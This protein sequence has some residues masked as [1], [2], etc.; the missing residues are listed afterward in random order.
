MDNCYSYSLN[1]SYADFI[2][3]SI[4]PYSGF[5]KKFEN[6]P[7]VCLMGMNLSTSRLHIPLNETD[8]STDS[9]IP[10]NS[11][12][13]LYTPM[14]YDPLG[15]TG[16]FNLRNINSL[17]LYGNG[18]LTAIIDTGVDYLNPYLI[19]SFGNSKIYRLWDQGDTTK[20][21]P[22][23]YLYGSEYTNEE[24]NLAI[25]SESA[26]YNIVPSKPSST[27]GTNLAVL[28]CGND[29][30]ND[31]FSGVAPESKLIIV[32]LKQ[33]K[34]YLLDYYGVANNALAF[35]EN[36]IMAAISYIRSRAYNLNLPVSILIGVGSS[37]GNHCGQSNLSYL[38]NSLSLTPGL[39]VTSPVGNEGIN[40][41]HFF[42]RLNDNLTPEL[43]ELN[44]AQNTSSLYL[45][46]WGTLPQLYKISIVS[47]SGERIDK[48]EPKLN[49]SSSF[50]F[51]FENTKLNL[52]YK[53]VETQSGDELI[54]LRFITPSS[55]IWRI[56]VY[57]EENYP[58]TFNAWLPAGNMLSYD[59]YF[60]N[61]SPYLTITDPATASNSLS[62]SGYNVNNNSI[63]QD[64]SKGFLP[65]GLIKPDLAAATS[66]F[67]SSF[68]NNVQNNTS[69]SYAAALAAGCST[70]ILEWAITNGNFPNITNNEI[71]SFLIRGA[72]RT[73]DK[74]YPDRDFGYGML[75]I[76]NSFK[77]IR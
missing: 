52:Q 30:V 16:I 69:S 36:D 71:K 19:D 64:S 28:A 51:L 6:N 65:N 73:P 34:Q 33:A 49:S 45:E 59:T 11:I 8:I 58:S 31:N 39:A 5:F 77:L 53:T 42:G 57:G 66:Q 29:S 55:G 41:R 47:P 26:A 18:V 14:D 1:E 4:N 10:Y 35:Q 13:S 2:V 7:N 48:I 21:P 38:I 54:L 44:I 60:L 17:N 61:S 50:S 67:F 23:P 46:I 24:I 75:N 9:S 68:P 62:I 72:I 12:P 43:I 15:A 74:I 20:N 37:R 40:R 56:Y 32:K 70:L 63:L 27:H 25:A 3:S 76:F 22:G